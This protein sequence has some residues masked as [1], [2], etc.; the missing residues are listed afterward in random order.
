MIQFD[1]GHTVNRNQTRNGIIDRPPTRNAEPFVPDVSSMSGPSTP[2]A[3][4][5]TNSYMSEEQSNPQE[6]LFYDDNQLDVKLQSNLNI[7]RAPSPA[8]SQSKQSISENRPRIRIAAID[9]SLS[10]PHQHPKGWRS[11]TYGWLFLPVSLIGQPFSASTRRHFLPL[12]SDP[13]WWSDTTQALREVFQV[14]PDFNEGMFSRQMA[15]VKGQGWN[16]V[17]SLRHADEGPLELCRRVKVLVWDDVID[18]ADNDDEVEEQDITERRYSYTEDEHD[19]DDA[20][21]DDQ[22]KSLPDHVQFGNRAS[23]SMDGGSRPTFDKSHTHSASFT[24][25]QSPAQSINSRPVP[26]SRQRS[27]SIYAK[28]LDAASGVDVLQHMDQLDA[29]EHSMH[30]LANEQDHTQ[31]NNVNAE[32]DDADVDSTRNA[33]EWL[34]TYASGNDGSE[35]RSQRPKAGRISTDTATSYSRSNSHRMP[36]APYKTR[37]V[38]V[39][40]LETVKGG[41]PYFETW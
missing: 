21:D 18:I 19:D 1:P 32:R 14:D 13:Q 3:N 31:V 11:Y 9:N 39:E 34:K 33:E 36:P 41:N 10:F 2:L 22:V 29:V 25:P 38:I 26:F 8:Q 28:S 37:K 35:Q 17:Q 23:R 15:I 40:R 7:P 4:P 6:S 12:L 30:Q 16:I 20:D 27:A 5:Q 24:P